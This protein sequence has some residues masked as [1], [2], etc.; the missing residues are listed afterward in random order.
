MDT[1]TQRTQPP[2]TLE[3]LLEMPSPE[4]EPATLA[5]L[6]A[7]IEEAA[8][9]PP[10]R[11]DRLLD[12][13]PL[14]AENGWC[15]TREHVAYV[16]VRTAMPGHTAQMWDWWFDWHPR[17]SLRYRAWFPEAHFGTRFE[18][19][20]EPGSKPFWG[21]V[22]Y[23]DEDI[24][25]G[26]EVVRIEFRR[27]SEYGFS[28]D[29]LEHPDVATIVGGFAGSPA[30]RARAGVMTHVLLRAEDGL[31][32]RSHFWLGHGMRPDLPGLAGD[33][34]GKLLDRPFVRRI[35][36]PERL[37]GALADHCAREY[38]RLS[39]ILPALYERYAEA[40]P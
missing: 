37:P 31:T 28:G 13:R 5:A 33:L 8:A 35:A 34:A 19:P 6:R 22:H 15:W 30:R 38:S 2:P 11:I 18:P 23:P 26:R 1:A 4:P 21:A 39:A 36:L 24:G 20:A 27:P 7:P 3:Q 40:G 9:L 10:S 32:L 25:L 17:E 12:P 29:A 14:A 16:A